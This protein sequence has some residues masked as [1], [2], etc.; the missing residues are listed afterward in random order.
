MQVPDDLTDALG[1]RALVT[2]TVVRRQPRTFQAVEWDKVEH[3]VLAL[4][5]TQDFVKFVLPVVDA[6]EERPLVLDRV[7]GLACVF[8]AQLHQFLRRNFWRAR[9]QVLAQV[10]LGA[11]Q[12]QRQRGLHA[13]L[14]QQVE[15]TAV[16]YGRKHQ[17]FV[18]DGAFS[19]EHVDGF[20]HIVKIVGRLT[21]AHKHHFFHCAYAA[22]KDHLREDFKATHLA[23][24]AAFAGHAEAA[25]NSATDLRR[26]AEPIARQ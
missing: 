18:A 7:A 2:L 11:M 9:Q 24:Q 1:V 17:V 12:R 21:H 5:Q 4:K 6:L 26:H 13:L 22:R 15:H 25:T 3:C 16:A 20:E 8:L 23:N 10:G 14:R 19:A